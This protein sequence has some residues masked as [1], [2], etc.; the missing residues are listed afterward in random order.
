ME[1]VV[2]QTARASACFGSLSGLRE[3]YTGG[4]VFR[5]CGHVESPS[6][7]YKICD[8]EGGPANLAQTMESIDRFSTNRITNPILRY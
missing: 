1:V 6:M 5:L 3:T 4:D 7:E 8:S 2:D